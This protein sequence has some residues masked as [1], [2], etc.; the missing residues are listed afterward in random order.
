MC[1]IAGYARICVDK[2]IE[3]DCI[4]PMLDAI[5]HRG[6]DQRGVSI[7]ANGH[8]ESLRDW[9]MEIFKA[10]GVLG[11]NRLSIRDLSK[12]GNQPY[13]SDEQ[14]VVMAFNGEIYN[15]IEWKSKLILMGYRFKG[16]SETEVLMN[17]Y[18]KF[19]IDKMLE[20]ING[21]FSIC[22]FDARFQKIYLVRDRFGAKPLYFAI[23][24]GVIIFAS[25]QKSILKYNG[26]VPHL[27]E[28]ALLEQ[29]V[30]RSPYDASLITGIE[31]VKPGTYLVISNGKLTKKQY[32]N[33]NS[34][35][36]YSNKDIS[37]EEACELFA[38]TFQKVIIDQKIS[39]VPIGM[40]LSGGIDSSLI[41]YYGN[42]NGMQLDGHSIYVRGEYYNEQSH[43]EHVKSILEL[44]VYSYELDDNIAAGI[45]RKTVYHLDTI[46]THFNALGFY[47]LSKKAASH[48]KVLLGGEGADELMGGYVQFVEGKKYSDHVKIG[49][50]EGKSHSFE[51]AQYAI[52]KDMHIS[53]DTCQ[54]ILNLDY[55]LDT[56]KRK[57][58]F[59]S[60]YGTDFDK[61]ARYLMTTHLE[62]LLVKQDKM[63]MANSIENRVPY[64][65]NRIVALCMTLPEEY[66]LHEVQRGNYTGKYILKRIASDIYG[67]DFAFSKKKGFPIP[68][69]AYMMA[70][71]FRESVVNK[72]LPAICSRSVYKS[73]YILKLFDHLPTIS[74]EEIRAL[75]KILNFEEWCELVGV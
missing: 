67:T 74:D 23:R 38:D 70:D 34:Y 5:S 48:C 54:R 10:E 39:D 4:G 29:F 50:Q 56:E 68:I 58:L 15:A 19:G 62:D 71:S 43:I 49:N 18:L 8:I 63:A 22:I 3:I 46:N 12:W 31:T 73:K 53:Q 13:V 32:F 6:P 11:F 61:Y 60:F 28:K 2:K 20:Q 26:F 1:G 17:M 64:L 51:Y 42:R 25:E 47:Q 52:E 21:I 65:D 16:K 44:N 66:L 27:N 72:L 37:F 57:N 14:N 33:L 45:F 41:A 30:F 35:K 9:N 24:D 7:W 75:W 55:R 59:Y 69:R 36:R 40:Q